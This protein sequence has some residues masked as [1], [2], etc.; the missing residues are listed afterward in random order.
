MKDGEKIRN[1]KE[2]PLI[3]KILIC[4]NGDQVWKLCEFLNGLCIWLHDFE[5]IL[6][7]YLK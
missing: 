2:F 3:F 4:F 1:I 6:T 7:M 5:N